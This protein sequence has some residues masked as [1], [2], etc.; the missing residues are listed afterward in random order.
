[1]LH[2]MRKYDQ[3]TKCVFHPNYM[4][5]SFGNYTVI[6]IVAVVSIILFSVDKKKYAISLYR[7]K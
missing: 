1:M 4:K 2:R 5:S 3:N 6:M 7:Q